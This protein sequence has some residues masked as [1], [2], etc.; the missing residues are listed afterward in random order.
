MAKPIK[1]GTD[2]LQG[3]RKHGNA[4][5]IG[6]EHRIRDVG[7]SSGWWRDVQNHECVKLGDPVVGKRSDGESEPA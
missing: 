2:F 4:L 7:A 5:G 6:K 1:C 3:E